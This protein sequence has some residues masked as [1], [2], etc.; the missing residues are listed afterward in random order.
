[1]HILNCIKKTNA[2]KYIIGLAIAGCLF[3]FIVLVYYE[4]L[5]SPKTLIILILVILLS[6]SVEWMY[7]KYSRRTLKK[8][9]V[10]N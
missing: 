1:M 9:K 6:F 8:R 4:I 2:N 5:H 10:T 7:R 3:S